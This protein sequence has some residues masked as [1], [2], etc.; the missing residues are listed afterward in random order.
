[1]RKGLLLAFLLVALCAVSTLG[2]SYLVKTKGVKKVGTKHP[3]KVVFR[4]L[5]KHP[6]RKRGPIIPPAIEHGADYMDDLEDY[7]DM[8]TESYPQHSD[9]YY[10]DHDARVNVPADVEHGADY[11]EGTETASGDYELAALGRELAAKHGMELQPEDVEVLKMQHPGQ[12]YADITSIAS[13][14]KRAMPVALRLRKENPEEYRKV[15]EQVKDN[16]KIDLDGMIDMVDEVDIDGL[17]DDMIKGRSG[18]NEA[19]GDYFEESDDQ[20]EEFTRK[21][22]V[23]FGFEL[24][25]QDKELFRAYDPKKGLSSLLGHYSQALDFGRRLAPV[26]RKLKSENP[27]KFNQI[28]DEF[29][30]KFNIDVLFLASLTG[31]LI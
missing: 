9:D 15:A 11:S 20:L 29:Q 14:A 1:M 4:G 25:E 16:F 27:E 30:Q 8:N 24:T 10:I 12:D 21:L 5:R 13:F 7:Y 6:N 23:E 2:K 19:A 28:V 31:M 3:G 22:S 18:G 17:G 26:A